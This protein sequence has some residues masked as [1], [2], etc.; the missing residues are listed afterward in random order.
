MKEQFIKNIRVIKAAIAERKLVIFAGSGISADAGVPTWSDLIDELRKDIDISENESD[1]LRIAQLYYNER[2]QKEFIDKI[3][4]VLQ[5]KKLRYNEIHEEIFDLNPEHIITT[6]FDD[7]L[8]QVIK[9][10][11]HPYSVI[12]KD[13]EFP[14]SR[15]T[16]LLV[17][18]HGD[19]DEANLVI[20]E[21]D[22]LEYSSTHPLIESFIKGIFA[23]KV[24]LFVGYSFSDLDLKIILQ[25]VRNVLGKDFQNAYLLSVDK[26]FHPSQR[27]YLR[28]KGI[29]V[30]NY[31]DAGKLF[32]DDYINQYL[33]VGRN[34]LNHSTIKK[35]NSLS[36][37]GNR[38][39]NLLQF[40]IKYNDFAESIFNENALSQMVK[41]LNRF[42]N[43][44][45]LPP[46][47]LG[48]LYPFNNRKDYIHNYHDYI[49]GSS[50]QKITNFFF[51]EIDRET[52]KLNEKFFENNSI[53]INKRPALDE[54]LEKTLRKLNYS[55][56][57]YFGRT[58]NK[59][60]T[61]NYPKE[62]VEKIDI[63]LPSKHC[64]CLSCK[65]NEFNFKGFLKDIKEQTITET[66]DL[67]NDMLIA[68]SNYK[69][70]NIKTSINQFEEIGNKAW[71][72]E[73]YV[74]YFISQH[75]VKILKHLLDW[76]FEDLNKE[77]MKIIRER[78][79]RLDLD[80]LMFQ[81]PKL[82][83]DVYELL[84]IIR[85]D[86]VLINAERKINELYD[87]I[88]DVYEHL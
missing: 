69:A 27:Q 26:E 33:L 86:E 22:Y 5:H 74:T 53:D 38:L 80:K 49:L 45:V 61:F 47:F 25:S 81:V 78:I 20:K 17:K 3:R 37:K 15:N 41:S 73:D 23:T 14:Y 87:R 84:K 66:S 30:I 18:I 59:V 54:L 42:N 36:E 34:A 44:R 24:V 35:I 12:K 79:E 9:S 32:D 56:I 83:D 82:N 65:Y 10:K 1:F 62:F 29:N 58:K 64:D 46:K 52:L 39:L 8:E 50:N 2:Q 19:L 7:L 40:I 75:N 43:I 77:G 48:N 57:F 63:D 11:A 4:E 16:K 6:N 21:D 70:G 71:Q 72:L 51:E 28:N 85:D 67:Q 76:N 13:S 68:Y 55:S 31:F 88:V 60:E